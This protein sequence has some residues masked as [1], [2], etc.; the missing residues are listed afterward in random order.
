MRSVLCKSRQIPAM[1]EWLEQLRHLRAAGTRTIVVTVARV[2][3]SAPRETGAKMLVTASTTMGTIGGGQLEHLCTR[4]ACELLASDEVR[5][6][7]S[8]TFPLGANCGQC[9]GGVVD[10]LFEECTTES[11]WF[12]DVLRLFDAGKPALLMSQLNNDGVVCREVIADTQLDQLDVGTAAA[13]REALFDGDAQHVRVDA[14]NN[15][16]IEPIV[17]SSFNIAVFGAGHVGTATVSMLATLDCNI[18][19][20][21]SRRNVFPKSMP[22]NVQAIRSDSPPLEVAAMPANS[23]FLTMTHSHAL[24]E[25]ICGTVLNRGDFAY[26]GLIGSQSKRRRFVRRMQST[27]VAN[28]ERL[29]CP[30]GVAGI[31]GKKPAEISVSVAAEILQ[32][33]ETAAQLVVDGHEENVFQIK[34]QK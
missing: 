22:A 15:F 19:W 11:A 8:R 12:D 31:S 34:G 2:R 25:D 33:R 3:G 24:D 14:K 20:V 27:G 16:L 28:I 21:D 18:R 30:I 32:I 7:V 1:H 13:A 4:I 26:C 5:A 6:P 10:V 23:F 29:T 9:C 17:T